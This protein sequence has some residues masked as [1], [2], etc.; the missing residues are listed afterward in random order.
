MCRLPVYEAAEH[1]GFLLIPYH[2]SDVYTISKLR[3]DT[4][5]MTYQ[6][7]T[8]VV[9]WRSSRKITDQLHD[10]EHMFCY[11]KR[12]R[13]RGKQFARLQAAIATAFT[14]DELRRLLKVDLETSLEAITPDKGF[15]AQVFDLLLWLERHGRLLEFVECARTNNPANGELA[16]A[17]T[18]VQES[19]MQ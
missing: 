4:V 15:E 14:R 9:S 18:A 3:T 6:T 17:C 5:G 10:L 7:N 19:G 2:L 13:L 11:N 8:R 12:M 16:A 1:D